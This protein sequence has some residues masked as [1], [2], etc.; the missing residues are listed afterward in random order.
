MILFSAK[1]TVFLTNDAVSG[2]PVCVAQG[3]YHGHG[4]PLGPVMRL[5]REAADPTVTACLEADSLM[6]S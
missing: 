2:Y 4:V 5:V 3:P 6:Y 1:P